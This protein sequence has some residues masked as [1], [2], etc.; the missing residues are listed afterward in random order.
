MHLKPALLAVATLA[1]SPLLA[2]QAPQA[3]ASA[4]E[5]ASIGVPNGHRLVWSDDFEGRGLPDA[6]KWSY[7]TAFNKNGWH[8]RE[9]Q[10][11]SAARA[12]NARL[13]NGRLIIEAHREQLDPKLFPDWGGQ[14]YSSARLVTRGKARWTYG[15]FEARAKLPCAVGTW[16]AIWTLADKPNMK[17]PDDGEID[18]MEHVGFNP[19]VVHQTIHTAAFNQSA[20]RRRRPRRRCPARA[21]PS[22]STSSTGPPTGSAWASMAVPFSA[23]TRLRAARRN[24]RSTDRNI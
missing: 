14:L 22:T 2:Q 17:W 4:A 10:Y 15:Y 1:V 9:K 11:Y 18:I 13:R 5:G 3:P 12:K 16:P 23:T 19:N 21:M 8:N 20:R 24:G 7:D 6:A